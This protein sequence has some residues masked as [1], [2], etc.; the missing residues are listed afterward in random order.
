MWTKAGGCSREPDTA[1][2]FPAAVPP[3]STPASMNRR[4]ESLVAP[5][6]P[7]AYGLLASLFILQSQP[8]PR[9]LCYTPDG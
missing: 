8:S 6:Q 9:P 3:L 7:S 1:L 5:F 2:L 4:H